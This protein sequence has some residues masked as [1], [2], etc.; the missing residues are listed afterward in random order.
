MEDKPKLDRTQFFDKNDLTSDYFQS[1]TRKHQPIWCK[2]LWGLIIVSCLGFTIY[3]VYNLLHDYFEYNS[4]NQDS[5]SWKSEVVLPA[6]TI[7]NLNVVDNSQWKDKITDDN[8]E[9]ELDWYLKEII[10]KTKKGEKFLDEERARK[11]DEIE[12]DGEK[13]H[14]SKDLHSDFKTFL[15]GDGESHPSMEFAD[16]WVEMQDI[17][18]NFLN[19]ELGNCLVLN[20]DQYFVQKLGGV[21]GGFTIDLNAKLENYLLST[22]WAG[23]ML[24]LRDPYELVL[25]NLDGI[26]LAPGKETFVSIEREDIT[27]LKAPHGTCRDTHSMFNSSKQLTIRECIQQEYFIESIKHCDCIPWHF[28]EAIQTAFTSQP[29]QFYDYMAQN[30]LTEAFPLEELDEAVCGY[31]KSVQCDLSVTEIL[32]SIEIDELCHEPCAYSDWKHQTSSG[33]FPATKGYFSEF[34]ETFIVEPNAEVLQEYKSGY[35]Y[36]T[37]NYARV[38]VFYNDL[39]IINIDQ[40]KAYEVFNFISEFGGA[41]DLLI[42]LSFFTMFQLFEIFIAYMVFKC[43]PRKE[44]EN[45]TDQA[46]ETV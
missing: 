40:T 45:S 5:I 46:K 33:K 20:D 44:K 25:N 1:I 19:T 39:K 38:H 8:L 3:T 24:Y 4:Y 42:G 29:Q 27:R 22:R 21:L 26:Y 30:G 34:L 14:I 11:L 35:E 37:E 10:I 23:F 6:M 2:C 16:K 18:Y 17:K 7:C 9:A 32:E 31:P 43:C 15:L 12:V 36:A 28:V 41:T 13:I